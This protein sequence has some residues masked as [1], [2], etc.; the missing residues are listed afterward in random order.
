[1][2]KITTKINQ[3]VTPEAVQ[4]ID[5]D[6][7]HIDLLFVKAVVESISMLDESKRLDCID[8]GTI[9][10]LCYAAKDKIAGLESFINS[11]HP[12]VVQRSMDAPG[13][14]AE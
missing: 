11:V 10:A 3:D 2:E 7:A 9:S 4:S 8:R 5:A 14:Q 12:L 6:T 13:V 1:M